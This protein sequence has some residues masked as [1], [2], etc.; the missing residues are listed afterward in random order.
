MARSQLLLYL[1]L[2]T[3]VCLVAPPGA[4]QDAGPSA[5]RAKQVRQLHLD[6]V[7]AAPNGA[8]AVEL[9][10]RALT[11]HGDPVD[12]LQARSL[13]IH[14][15][16]RRIDPSDVEIRLLRDAK[17][18]VACVLAI[19]V[20]PTMRA[21]AQAEKE[22][23]ESF[24]DR[25]GSYDRVAVVSFASDVKTVADFTASQADAR[26]SLDTLAIRPDPAPT[27]VYDGIYR[28]VELIRKG[29]HLPRRSLVIVFSD[30]D[31]GGS[32][33]SLDDIIQLARG[34]KGEPSVQVFTIGYPTGYGDT[35]LP[36]LQR[37]ARETSSAYVEASPGTSLTSFYGDIWT[38]MMQSYV[39]RFPTDLDG[40]VHKIDV[41]ADGLAE[42][43]RAAQYPLVSAPVWPYV[44]VGLL[45]LCVLGVAAFLFVRQSPGRLEF[46]S[47]PQAGQQIRLKLGRSRIGAQ[48]DNDVVI[49]EKTVSSRHAELR[50]NG[51]RAEIRDLDSTNG[52]FVNEQRVRMSPLRRGDRIRIADVDLVY[53]R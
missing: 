48:S 25:L 41:V 12:H 31:D 6:D 7:H 23:A 47:G 13:V 21:E 38:Q 4:A 9:Y 27:R 39:V 32:D 52:T 17:R 33:H 51:W 16:D 43:K 35:G 28:A 22:A 24:V 11:D 44:V 36:G 29:A 10:L 19:D 3:A 42:D 53:R 14:E 30:G 34:G 50:L 49:S 18:G 8:R 1:L 15:D 5:L 2:A 46:V 40:K 37:L 26:R 45:L 20:S